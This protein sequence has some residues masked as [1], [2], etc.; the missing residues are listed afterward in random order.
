MNMPTVNW[1]PG[2][3]PQD[4][5]SRFHRVIDAGFIGDHGYGW[6][7]RRITVIRRLV[8]AGALRKAVVVVRGGHLAR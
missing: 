8:M 3:L 1:C 6:H 7:Q 4:L 5:Y 2:Q